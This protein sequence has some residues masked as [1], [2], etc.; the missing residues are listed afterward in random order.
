[1]FNIPSVGNGRT[2]KL[3]PYLKSTRIKNIFGN[4]DEWFIRYGNTIDYT[5]INGTILSVKKVDA[6][7]GR[8]DSNMTSFILLMILRHL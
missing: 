3:R 4:V 8:D 5:D 2:I 1:M 7:A 6:I